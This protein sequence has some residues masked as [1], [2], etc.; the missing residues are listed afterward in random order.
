MSINET[1][2]DNSCIKGLTRQEF[3]KKILE[4]AAVAGTLAAVIN[5]QISI[6]PSVAQMATTTAV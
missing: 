1:E 4:K 6:H 3:I 5:T 2:R